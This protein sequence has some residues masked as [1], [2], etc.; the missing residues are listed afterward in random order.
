MSE[1]KVKDNNVRYAQR[2]IM[3]LCTAQTLQ[4]MHQQ[5]LIIVQAVASYKNHT[6]SKSSLKTHATEAPEIAGYLSD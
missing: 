4:P 5:S 1:D 6:S 3:S 2:I